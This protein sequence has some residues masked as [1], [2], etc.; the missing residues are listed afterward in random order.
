VSG[1]IARGQGENHRTF[2]FEE[3]WHVW[4]WDRSIDPVQVASVPARTS[5]EELNGVRV[6]FDIETMLPSEELISTKR[7]QGLPDDSGK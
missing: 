4:V 3:R 2:S 6:N 5:Y 1:I 7:E